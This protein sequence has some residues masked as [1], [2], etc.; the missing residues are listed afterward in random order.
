MAGSFG[1]AASA[2]FKRS[3]DRAREVL[4]PG[5]RVTLGSKCGGGSQTVTFSHWGWLELPIPDFSYFSARTIDELHPWNIT[6]V[7]GQPVSF[8]DP[9]GE[10]FVHANHRQHDEERRLQGAA[11]IQARRRALRVVTA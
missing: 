8:R 4:K 5:D 10:A 11:R 2:A 9:E 7:N 6:K 1:P 3:A